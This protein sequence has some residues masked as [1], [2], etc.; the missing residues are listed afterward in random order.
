MKTILLFLTVL[1]LLPSCKKEDPQPKKTVHFIFTSTKPFTAHGYFDGVY[2]KE[3]GCDS[4]T[5]YVDMD[6]P[7]NGNQQHNYGWCVTTDYPVDIKCKMDG[8]SIFPGVTITGPAK[9]SCYKAT[10]TF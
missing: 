6:Y 1:L 4:G 2:S 9:D 7:Y 3:I 8:G 5:V 10:N